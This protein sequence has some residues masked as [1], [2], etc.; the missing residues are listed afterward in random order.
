MNNNKYCHY[1]GIYTRN[2][3]KCRLLRLFVRND[4]FANDKIF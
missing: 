1:E 4:E 2:N 3:P